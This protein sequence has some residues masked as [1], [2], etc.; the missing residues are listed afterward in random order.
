MRAAKIATYTA[1][2]AGLPLA[3][4]AGAIQPLIRVVL[5]DEWLPT[6][7]IVLIGSLG[8]M[9]TASA[10]ATMVGFALAEGK[11]GGALLAAVVETALAFAMGVA[12]TASMGETGIGITM[13]VSMLA[14]TVAF[15][16][17]TDP[18]VRRSLF[19]VSKACAIAVAAAG[20]TQ[21]LGFSEDVTG[22]ILSL[23][24]TSA[25][26]LVLELIFSRAEIA[27]VVQLA[28]PI[29]RPTAAA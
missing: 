1:I 6:T 21:L 29:L 23:A 14:A 8:M 22:L 13:T 24:V 20:V 3:L 26:W 12:L 10:N 9:L 2:A 19:G 15:A 17:T 11:A 5:G 16:I 25:I 4:V 18:T 28:R 7:D 27:K